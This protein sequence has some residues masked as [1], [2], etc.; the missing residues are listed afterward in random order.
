MVWLNELCKLK[1]LILEYWR[2]IN[3]LWDPLRDFNYLPV[4]EIELNRV[5]HLAGELSRMAS[6]LERQPSAGHIRDGTEGT[7]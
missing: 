5:R 4:S 1:H 6:L 3:P 7:R 2:F